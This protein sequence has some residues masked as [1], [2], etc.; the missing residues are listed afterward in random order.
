MEPNTGASTPTLTEGQST[1]SHQRRMEGKDKWWKI[2]VGMGI[3]RDIKFRAPYYVSD[4]TDAWNYRV[5]P[6]TWVGHSLVGV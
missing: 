2:R 1:P 5:V 6:A 3:I 4:W